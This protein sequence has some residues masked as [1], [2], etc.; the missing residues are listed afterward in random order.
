MRRAAK[1][2]GNQQQIVVALRA[3]G[4]RVKSL[5]SVGEG[6]PDLLVAFRGKLYLLEVKRN[7]KAKLTAEQEKFFAEWT[8]YVARVNSVTEALTAIGL[9]PNGR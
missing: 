3:V 9:I 6:C 8:G 7:S 5:A 1:V 4:A 2:D